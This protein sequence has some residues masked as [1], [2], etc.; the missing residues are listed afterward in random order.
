MEGGRDI[1][2]N[3]TNW[4][5]KIYTFTEDTFVMIEILNV[6][7]QIQQQTHTKYFMESKQTIPF[8]NR[9]PD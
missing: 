6:P 1:N 2:R 7:V 3:K 4:V 8:Y 9:F 5:Q